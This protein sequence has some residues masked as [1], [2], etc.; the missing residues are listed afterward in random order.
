MERDYIIYGLL[1]PFTLDLR[2]V[3]Q[4][5]KGVQRG[6][7]HCRPSVLAKKENRHNA[8]WIKSV[9]KKGKKPEVVVLERFESD[10]KLDEAEKEW[11]AEA[12]RIGCRLNN[13][14]EGG[15]KPP[16]T[17]MSPKERKRRSE[18]MMG[19]RGYWKDKKFSEEHKQLIAGSV[20]GK[21]KPPRTQ[22][23]CRNSAISQGAKPF[24]DENGNLYYTKAEAARVLGIVRAD[25]QRLLSGKRKTA[26]GHTLTYI[27]EN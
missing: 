25:V 11:I 3:G 5:V 10:E 19:H 13:V 8:A 16:I 4:S 1:D 17:I 14:T 24:K 15:N 22:E 23:H 20:K 27:G 9:M 2:Y 12:R 18:K 26:K 21:A 7:D 6:R